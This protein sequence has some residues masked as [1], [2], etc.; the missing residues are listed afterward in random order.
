MFLADETWWMLP[1]DLSLNPA[2]CPIFGDAIPDIRNSQRIGSEGGAIA[3]FEP[4]CRLSGLRKTTARRSGPRYRRNS[5]T[6]SE[7]AIRPPAPATRVFTP[8]R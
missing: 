5:K 1:V 2:V 6:P 8:S 3:G 4:E 7:R